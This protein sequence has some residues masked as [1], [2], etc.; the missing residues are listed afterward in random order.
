MN[1]TPATAATR[2]GSRKAGSGTATGSARYGS[3][4]PV[5]GQAEKLKLDDTWHWQDEEKEYEHIMTILD[6]QG[7]FGQTQSD[8]AFYVRFPTLEERRTACE[9]IAR[10][11]PNCGEGAHFA[12]DCP[13]PF[14]NV[15]TQIN[16]DVGSCNATETKKKWRTWH[17]RLK[18]YYTNRVRRFRRTRNK[19]R[20]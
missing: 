3:V 17:A 13:K 1:R 14:I 20:K 19:S 5:V 8:P 12:R 11:C 4:F 7:G 18:K 2:P 10:K 6:S 15:S 16:T 9:K